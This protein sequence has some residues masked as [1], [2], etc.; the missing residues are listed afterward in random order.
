MAKR[1][2]RLIKLFLGLVVVLVLMLGWW[3]FDSYEIYPASV[4]VDHG[5]PYYKLVVD[6]R[7]R[8]IVNSPWFFSKIGVII[9]L[10]QR[11]TPGRYDFPKELSNYDIIRKLWRGEVAV[12]SVTVPEGYNMKQVGQLLNQRCGVDRAVFD[13]L[14]RD[15][16]FLVELGLPP[17]APIA[18]EG[19]LFPETY[20]F[21]W[22][23]G[24]D[25]AIGEM[26]RQLAGNLD[27]K[28]I[29]RGRLM[30]YEVSDILKMASIIQ[31][32]GWDEAEFPLIASVYRNRLN[33]GMKL[34]ADPTVI[35][36]MGG[37]DRPL[38]IKDYQFPSRYNTYLHKGLPP[39]PIC[40]PGMSA[41]R[42]ALYPDSTDYLYFVADGNGRH[43]FNSTYQKHLETM[44][45]IKGR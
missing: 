17:T 34:Q 19:Y 4:L 35:Y 28:M 45:Q 23:I 13:S 16:A 24:A 31:K 30:G 12:M 8:G 25:F 27:Q 3:L 44:R 43:I 6:L 36:G 15:S 22:G 37:L 32:E 41:I 40:S 20:R 18:A 21:Q 2:G 26:T 33:I 7:D 42:A 29:D 5:Q 14:V 10:D 38:R 11:L 9:G 39:T 1:L